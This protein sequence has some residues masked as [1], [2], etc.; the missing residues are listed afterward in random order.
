[1]TNKKNKFE[2]KGYVPNYN[3]QAEM[4]AFTSGYEFGEGNLDRNY[5]ILRY[6]IDRNIPDA[7]FCF[8]KENYKFGKM[9]KIEKDKLNECL[10]KIGKEIIPVLKKNCY[11]TNW[12]RK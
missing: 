1:M 6:R 2:E 5:H 9:T 3:T 11:K 12:K 8:P 4:D 7:L 10:M